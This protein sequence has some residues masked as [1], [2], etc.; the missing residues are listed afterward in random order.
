MADELNYAAE[1]EIII[2][3]IVDGIRM[4]F[5]GTGRMV[6]RQPKNRQI[7]NLVGGLKTLKVPGPG[8]DSILIGDVEVERRKVRVH[9]LRRGRY[10]RGHMDR[11]IGDNAAGS[12]RLA[13][14]AERSLVEVTPCIG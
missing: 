9:D 1:R 12:R 7:R 5:R 3:L 2:R 4:I 14:L 13:F 10:G 8:I 6:V 11:V